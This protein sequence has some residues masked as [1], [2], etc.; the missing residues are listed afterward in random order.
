MKTPFKMALSSTAFTYL[1]LL[2]IF[3]VFATL[4]YG[5]V[6]YVE[7]I[8]NVPPIIGLTVLSVIILVW[9]SF[10]NPKNGK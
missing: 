4:E 6:E 1:A 3:S 8:S 2:I 10:D 9:D 5:I 7:F